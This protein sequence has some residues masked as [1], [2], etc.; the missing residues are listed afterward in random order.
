MT[1]LRP[2][3]LEVRP[4]QVT[5]DSLLHTPGRYSFAPTRNDLIVPYDRQRAY[6]FRVDVT[7]LTSETFFLHAIYSGTGSALIPG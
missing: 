4:G 3:R 6:W 1:C 2:V 5:I 7:N